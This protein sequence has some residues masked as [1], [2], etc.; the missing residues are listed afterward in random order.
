M[1]YAADNSYG[2]ETNVGFGNRR[3]TDARNIG[4]GKT[5]QRQDTHDAFV[6]AQSL[7]RDATAEAVVLNCPFCWVSRPFDVRVP[8]RPRRP[9]H[10]GYTGRE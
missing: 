3:G 5:P 6:K 9:H 7:A 4:H 2:S 1:F 10:I 8:L